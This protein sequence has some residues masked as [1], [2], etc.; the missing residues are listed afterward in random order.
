MCRCQRRSQWR[1][2]RAA[3]ELL[4]ARLVHRRGAAVFADET[5]RVYQYTGVLL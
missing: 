3:A 4:P 2:R 1:R 5:L